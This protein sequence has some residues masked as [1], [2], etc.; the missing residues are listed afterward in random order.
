MIVEEDSGDMKKGMGR[1]RVSKDTK[2]SAT[3]LMQEVG[4]R[5]VLVSVSIVY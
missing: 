1:R 4:C 3:E 2:G 5:V